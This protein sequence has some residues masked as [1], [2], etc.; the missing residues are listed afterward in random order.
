MSQAASIASCSD[1]Q[2]A[3][4][5]PAVTSQSSRSTTNCSNALRVTSHGFVQSGLYEVAITFSAQQL[6]C[7]ARPHR[8]IK[9]LK[10]AFCS[11]YPA[12]TNRGRRQ[13]SLIYGLLNLQRARP[14]DPIHAASDG[15]LVPRRFPQS[16]PLQRF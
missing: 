4:A 2:D 14:F 16:T 9:N 3:R 1:G 10:A 6:H 12:G 7:A 13:L 15:P 8:T 5:I 11:F